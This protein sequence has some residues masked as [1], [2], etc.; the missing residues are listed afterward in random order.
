MW[1]CRLVRDGN[2]SRLSSAA[3]A[4]PGRITTLAVVGFVLVRTGFSVVELSQRVEADVLHDAIDALRLNE[5]ERI[6][7]SLSEWVD[8][9]NALVGGPIAQAL[10]LRADHY[11]G[12]WAACRDH[13]GPADLVLVRSPRVLE[14][15][16]ELAVTHLRALLYPREFLSFVELPKNWEQLHAAQKKQVYLLEYGTAPR[17]QHARFNLL[18]EEEGVFRLSRIRR[19]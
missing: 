1:A 18:T 14:L 6:R 13:V 7:R 11:H 16:R 19:R 4:S 15:Q 17:L 9:L 3:M 5:E 8:K 2:A 12:M 10:A